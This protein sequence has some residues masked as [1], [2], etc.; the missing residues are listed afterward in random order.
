VA[1]AAAA[2]AGLLFFAADWGLIRN[3]YHALCLNRARTEADAEPHVR[4]L[5][6]RA[7]DPRASLALVAKLG[8]RHPRLTFWVFG[9][10]REL[11]RQANT[12]RDLGTIG[13]SLIATLPWLRHFGA[14]LERDPGLLAAWAHYL[15]WSEALKWQK[16][17]SF[18][19]PPPVV[20]KPLR[21]DGL[22]LLPTVFLSPRF[23][24]KAGEALAPSGEPLAG[25]EALL[26][27][28]HACLTAKWWTQ[29]ASAAHGIALPAEPG[30]EALTEEAVAIEDL[31]VEV[32]AWFSGRLAALRFALDSGRCREAAP[33]AGNLF[34][35]AKSDI[36]PAAPLPGWEEEVPR[37][38]RVADP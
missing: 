13:A 16:I 6:D 34:D 10:F 3:E 38:G 29:G 24:V 7:R 8:E 2:V 37:P 9:H 35:L 28:W 32:A 17:S 31:D 1:A 30:P 21:L 33:G 22:G 19:C 12:T 5:L 36:V 25:T 14:R 15:R 4:A 23:E 18:C 26:R 11:E 27:L 20:V